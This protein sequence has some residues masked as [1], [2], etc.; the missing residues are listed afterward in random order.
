MILDEPPKRNP[1][2]Q[3]ECILKMGNIQPIFEAV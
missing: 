3:P 2:V 1:E